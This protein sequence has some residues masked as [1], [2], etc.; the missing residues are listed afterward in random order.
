MIRKSLTPLR[1]AEI[2]KVS[3]FNS[4]DIAFAIVVL[5]HPGGPHKINE[6][7]IFFLIIRD[8]IP[9]FESIFLGQAK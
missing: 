5:P 4:L 7:T 2:S 6:E 8:K 3:I 1:T 9:S